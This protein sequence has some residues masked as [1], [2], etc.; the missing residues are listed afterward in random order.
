M[1]DPVGQAAMAGGL[2]LGDVLE[3]V[4]DGFSQSAF[5]E[6]NFIPERAQAGLHLF[7]ECGE[8]LDSVRPE[9]SEKSLG[10]GAAIAKEFSPQAPG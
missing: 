9:L 8:E 10:D 2:E 4:D 6:Q 7:F 1:D 3:L 5:A